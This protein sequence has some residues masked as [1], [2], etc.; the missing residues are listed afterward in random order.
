[1]S[2]RLLFIA[3][4]NF[5][6]DEGGL[7][8]S[9]KQLKAQAFPYDQIDCE[10]LLQELLK[11][12]VLVEY[13]AEGKKYLHI[14]G[15]GTHQKIEKK[16]R[17]RH[18]VYRDSPTTHRGVGECSPSS[19]VSSLESKGRD[20]KK[21]TSASPPA[22]ERESDGKTKEIVERVFAHWQTE[23]GK[24]KAVL[25]GKRRKI[26]SQALKGYDE[27]TLCAAISGYKFSPFHMGKNENGTVYNDIG[28]IL[29]NAGQID[30]GLEFA[31]S[32]PADEN[33][34]TFAGKPM[35]WR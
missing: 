17:P 26:I 20:H 16:A 9:A 33:G 21:D 1:M 24:H 8:R 11:A 2:A 29:R 28:L 7:E 34:A 27:A 22:T 23:F 19:A 6:D 18:P 14:K 12:G 5:A 15:F 3:T 25:D 13:E 10:P 35:E 32:K 30:K 4:W 31:R